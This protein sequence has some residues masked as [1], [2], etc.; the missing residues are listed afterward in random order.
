MHEGT[1]PW[2]QDNV[3]NDNI[4]YIIYEFDMAAWVCVGYIYSYFNSKYISTYI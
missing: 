1:S 3:Y 4:I 2:S